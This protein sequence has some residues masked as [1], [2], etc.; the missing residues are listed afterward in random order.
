[1]FCYQCEQAA[2]GT[3]CNIS[4]VC[5]KKEDIQSLQDILLYGLKGISA[6]AFHSR[7]LGGTDKDVD[8]FIHEAL[9]ATVTNVNFDQ[10]RYLEMILKCGEINLKIM[11]LLDRMHTE[12]F[13]N[14]VPVTVETGTKAGPGILVTGHDL[15]D[16][17]I[18]LQQTEGMGINVYT[19]GEMLPAHGYPELKKFKHLVGN[20]GGAW[21]DQKKEF[22]EFPC[23]LLAT[24]NCVLIP[25]ENT[26]LDRLFTCGIAGIEGA[27][28]I[29]NRD[30][31]EVIKKAKSLPP[32]PDTKGKKIMTG[33]HHTAILG[34]A[35][36]IVEAVKSGKI[37]HFFLIGG[38]DGAKPGRNYYTKFAE[39]VPDDCVILTLACGKYR[40]NNLDFGDID[41]IPRLI[42]IGQCNNAYSAIQVAAA[43]TKVFNCGINELP[44][45]MIL[46]WFEQKA[47]AILLTLFYLG[48]KGIRLGPTP[49]AFISPN[50]MK[51]LQEKFDI[52]L[53]T[54]PEEDLDYTD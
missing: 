7:E 28:H 10:N 31:S 26:Y 8:G 48:V 53:I 54:T 35:D 52:K 37:S 40:F 32:L 12:K 44:L 46:S 33:F 42:D 17:Y 2:K 16:L 18:L 1:M 11:E 41:G 39:M 6:Y 49:P 14:P 13:G 50:V 30:F 21:Q 5:G 9:F 51:L 29:R 4:G 38:C 22:K 24:T 20:Y 15:L 36:K 47:V 34:M 45:S 3:G 27:T 19:H 43:L 25:P 23:A